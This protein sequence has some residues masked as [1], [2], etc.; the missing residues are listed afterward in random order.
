MVL[1]NMDELPVVKENAPDEI[2]AMISK[3]DNLGRMNLVS[4]LMPS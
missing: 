2:V 4:F 1:P 3:R